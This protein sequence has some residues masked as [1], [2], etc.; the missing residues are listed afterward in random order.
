MCLRLILGFDLLTLEK[1][2]KHEW[3]FITGASETVAIKDNPP[4]IPLI[5]A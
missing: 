2:T 3:A 5:R 4:H 1:D